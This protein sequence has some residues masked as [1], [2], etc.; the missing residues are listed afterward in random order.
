MKL[1]KVFTLTLVGVFLV[2]LLFS[3]EGLSQSKPEDYPKRPIEAVVVA[4]PGGGSDIFTRTICIPVR[5]ALKNPLIV[6]NK[7]GGGGAVAGEYVQNKSADGYTLLSGTLLALVESPLLGLV[8]YTYSDWQPVMRAQL[9][10][11]MLVASEDSKFK[12]IQTVI[13]DAKASPGQQTWGVVGTPTG[14]NAICARQF[15]DAVGI[16]VKLV[17][18]DRT[19]KQHAALLG[20]HIDLMMEE[21]GPIGEL[22]E[23]KKVKPLLVFAKNRIKDFP[24]VP[25]TKELGADAFMGLYRGIAVK[26]GTP[27][28]IVHYLDGV[29]RKA[30]ESN[31]YKQYEKASYLHLRPGYLGPDG[32]DTFLK[33]QIDIYTREFKRFKVY[34]PR[35]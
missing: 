19:G 18:F 23:A 3:S 15:T 14:F 31:F 2:P 5:R 28:P 6:I 22:I 8:T 30:M 26:K 4:G 24:N 13:A 34:R 1:R 33:E 11:M 20:N 10:T 32:F 16:E 9:D 7:P 21:P 29:F 27:K 35:K 17:P 12:D 25:T